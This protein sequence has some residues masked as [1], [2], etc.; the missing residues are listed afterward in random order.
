MATAAATAPVSI[1]PSDG[2]VPCDSNTVGIE[3]AFFTY[4]DEVASTIMPTTFES[5]GADICVTG[6]VGLVDE[7]FSVWGA[8]LGFNFADEAPWDAATQGISGVSFNISE[9]PAGTETR[10]IFS[11]GAGVDHCATSAAAGA[12]TFAFTDT[13]V[14]CWEA[15]G[16]TPSASSIVS[17]KWQV[18]T[19]A[20]SSHPFSFCITDLQVIP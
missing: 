7:A 8:G 1:T 2:W 15:G 9:L 6:E 19:N 3:G 13:S 18:A 4:F 12:N 14:D 11:D 5:A 20:E 17:V 10:I 16:A